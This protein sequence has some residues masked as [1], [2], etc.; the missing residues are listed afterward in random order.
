MLYLRFKYNIAD[1]RETDTQKE[2]SPKIEGKSSLI[3]LDLA[4]S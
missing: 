4:L 1:M 2:H 3:K